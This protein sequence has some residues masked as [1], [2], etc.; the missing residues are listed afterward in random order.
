MDSTVRRPV[1][2]FAGAL[3]ARWRV[4]RSCVRESCSPFVGSR[5]GGISGQRRATEGGRLTVSRLGTLVDGD[6]KAVEARVAPFAYDR[7]IS[8]APG[9]RVLADRD[10]RPTLIVQA[11]SA[12]EMHD[13]KP[14][15]TEAPAPPRTWLNIA[16]LGVSG[17]ALLLPACG[18][19][20]TSQGD[21]GK[22]SLAGSRCAAASDMVYNGSV[23]TIYGRL[24]RT[25]SAL[26]PQM[27]EDLL[28]RT[29]DSGWQV[30][31]PEVRRGDSIATTSMRFS[32]ALEGDGPYRIMVRSESRQEVIDL[33][34]GTAIPKR[35]GVHT[36]KVRRE[37]EDDLRSRIRE[38][39]A[40]FASDCDGKLLDNRC[41]NKPRGIRS[42]YSHESTSE[43]VVVATPQLCEDETAY[44]RVERTVGARTLGIG[45]GSG[46]RG[47]FREG[48]MEM[49][50]D[51][52][53]VDICPSINVFTVMHV[54]A[55][56][57]RREGIDVNG[58]GLGPCGD[59]AGDYH[60]WNASV[61]VTD[62]ADAARAAGILGDIFTRYDLR[63]YAGIAVRGVA[64]GVAL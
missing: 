24:R 64:C 35:K 6:A 29:I 17:A 49:P 3:S 36:S 56:K 20:G 8:I 45:R 16:S 40:A 2:R 62:W 26:Y 33:L 37:F 18:P 39:L 57:M 19:T 11:M 42:D 15:P 48:C 47:G 63:G 28:L 32:I 25:L 44:I 54:A 22:W 59:V 46:N 30:V 7:S 23:L 1:C 21:T 61:G 5:N 13:T 4:F 41:T 14:F 55:D 43:E 51:I 12:S 60:K 50:T 38:G 58:T 31:E 53:N 52:D 9:I 10:G 34:P 27:Q